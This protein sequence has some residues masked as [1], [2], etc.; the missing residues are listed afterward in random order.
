MTS[1]KGT[2]RE[3]FTIRISEEFVSFLEN[4]VAAKRGP[5][6]NSSINGIIDEALNVFV[7]HSSGGS[8]RYDFSLRAALNN[9][10]FIRD[11]SLDKNI[12][13]EIIDKRL[14]CHHHKF[15]QTECP[16]TIWASLDK[17]IEKKLPKVGLP[18][19]SIKHHTVWVR[20]RKNLF[21]KINKMTKDQREALHY[22]ENDML[23]KIV[24]DYY[25]CKIV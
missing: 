14:Y 8:N 25:S 4:E 2:R 23:M 3:W 9:V 21:E 24:L 13:I 15:T 18:F 1:I 22:S 16:H 11:P 20:V 10:F 7:T 5:E 19:Y 6:Q 17:T 12:K